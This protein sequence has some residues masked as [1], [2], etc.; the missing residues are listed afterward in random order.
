MARALKILALLMGVA[1]A[2]IGLSDLVLG[3]ASVPGE[4]SAGASVDSR[5]RFYSAIFL[6]PGLAWIWVVR[7]SPIPA[8][9]SRW[10]FYFAASAG[11]SP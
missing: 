1:C 6:G 2:L 4:G 8:G 5:E 3:I 9:D 7:R 11:W 10:C